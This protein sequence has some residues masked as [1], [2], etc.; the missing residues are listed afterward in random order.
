MCGAADIK[1]LKM[2]CKSMNCKLRTDCVDLTGNFYE[3]QIFMYDRR[4]A[5]LK[6]EELFFG[7]FDFLLKFG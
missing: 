7:H 1:S 6:A 3:F 5:V 2:M 4:P